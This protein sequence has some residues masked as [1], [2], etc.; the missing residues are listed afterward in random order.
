ML[1]EDGESAP[2]DGATVYE[3]L[4]DNCGLA[5]WPPHLH[6]SASGDLTADGPENWLGF[7]YPQLAP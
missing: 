6:V 3:A 4:V 1:A 7:G 5:G 2:V